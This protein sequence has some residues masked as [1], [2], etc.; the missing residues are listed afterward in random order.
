MPYEDISMRISIAWAGFL[1]LLWVLSVFNNRIAYGMPREVDYEEEVVVITGGASGLGRLI[2]DFYAMRGTAVAVLDIKKPEDGTMMGIQY[3]HCDVS[4]KVQ[5]METV[6]KI[7][8]DVSCLM[9]TILRSLF[10]LCVYD[11]S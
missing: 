3:F 4:D 9:H 2:A 5:V 6:A 10:C 11:F 7:K 8:K 1:T